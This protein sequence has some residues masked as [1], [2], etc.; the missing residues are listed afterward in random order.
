MAGE[1][2]W[3]LSVIQRL[4]KLKYFQ[5]NPG[6]GGGEGVSSCRPFF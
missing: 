4:A 1:Q 6:T 5:D 2:L 3:R